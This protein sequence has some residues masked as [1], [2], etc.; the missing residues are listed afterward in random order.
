M[1]I[2][3]S[4]RPPET[5]RS[6]RWLTRGLLGGGLL[7]IV[8]TA[9]A[10]MP[11]SESPD[12]N[13]PRLTHTVKRGKL[14]VSVTENGTLE[15]SDNVEIK[16]QVRG[17]NTVTYVVES[18]T[19]VY[20]GDLLVQLDTL[21]IEE[22][23]NERTKYAHWSRSAAERSDADVVRATL[24]VSEYEQGQYIAELMTLEKDL[25]IAEATLVT[26]QNMLNH[27]QSLRER[28]YRSQLDVEQLSLIHI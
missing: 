1:C 4:L 18:G 8:T 11:R 9:V 6:G 28:G 25:A 17:R 15:S 21:F 13:G 20:P 22:Q 2:R 27:E 24:A 12:E 23:I 3:D 7:V 16:C 14:V 19:Y 5:P 10:M 26:A